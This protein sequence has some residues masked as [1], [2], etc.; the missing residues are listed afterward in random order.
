MLGLFAI[1]NIDIQYLDICELFSQNLA[2]VLIHLQIL[3]LIVNWHIWILVYFFLIGN[4]FRSN[5]NKSAIFFED[6]TSC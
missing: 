6:G 4:L 2:L 1:W 5:A 3:N